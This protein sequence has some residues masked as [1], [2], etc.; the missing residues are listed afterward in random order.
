M[1]AFSRLRCCSVAA[2]A[3][4]VLAGAWPHALLAAPVKAVATNDFLNSIGINATHPDRGQPLEKTI[5]M[6]RYCGF[7]WIRAGVFGVTENGPTTIKTFLD[8]YRATGARVSW[9]A[10]GDD[11]DLRKLLHTGRILADAGALLAFE[12]V[13]EPNNWSITYQGEKG[14]G[15]ESWMAIAKMQRDLYQAV[16]GDP[17]LARYPVFSVS[18]TGAQND[19]VGLQFLK[20]P[21]GAKTLM[22]DGTIYADYAN[23]HNYI[24]HPHS[25]HPADNKAWDAAEPSSASRVNGLFGNFGLTWGRKYRGYTEEQLQSLPRVTTETGVLIEGQMTEDLHAV[26]L[27]NVYLVQFKRGYAYTS[28]Y[29]LRDR[30]DEAGNQSFGYYRPD[31]SPRKAALYIHNFTTILSDKPTSASPAG[32]LDYAIPNQPKTV[33]DLLL[34]RSDGAFQLVVWGERLSGED[35]IVVNLGSRMSGKIYDPTIGTEPVRAFAD[36]NAIELTLSDHP[37]VIEIPARSN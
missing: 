6:V 27:L 26:H 24:Y 1:I 30:T 4:L 18:E 29:L 17:V 5:E 34:R 19:N 10:N 25:S 7:R 11:N 8:M 2:V 20:I 23:V 3:L 33:H 36:S 12:G 22:P 37:V 28:V 35:R 32:E 16:K 9:M 31:Y 14:G 13:N 21:P 15:R